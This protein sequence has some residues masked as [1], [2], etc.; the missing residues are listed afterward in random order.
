LKVLHGVHPD[1]F[2]IYG[3]EQIRDRFLIDNLIKADQINCAYT[4]YDRIILGV[5]HP[6]TNTLT[7]ENHPDLKEDYFLERREIGIINVGGDG[8]VDADGEVFKLKKLD[9]LYIG[10]GLKK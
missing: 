7:L 9:C 6:I 4:H 2:K 1:D 8:E 10:K 5:A 3:T